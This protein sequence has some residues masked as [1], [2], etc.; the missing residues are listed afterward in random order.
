LCIYVVDSHNYALV[1]GKEATRRSELS[2]I[3]FYW[4]FLPANPLDLRQSR[5]V[6]IKS[7]E[8]A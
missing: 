6:R 5:F 3:L 4:L 8:R 1:A 2:F 7:F